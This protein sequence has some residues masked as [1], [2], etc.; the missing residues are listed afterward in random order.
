MTSTENCQSKLYSKEKFKK[1]N[2][3]ESN[4]NFSLSGRKIIINSKIPK[5]STDPKSMLC[6]EQFNKNCNGIKML[7]MMNI[8]GSSHSFLTN[9]NLSVLDSET[10]EE[11]KQRRN[12]A[13]QEIRRKQAEKDFDPVL[14]GPNKTIEQI[15]SEY[16]QK[17]QTISDE[18]RYDDFDDD[19]FVPLPL[20]SSL[21]NPNTL[22]G[23]KKEKSISDIDLIYWDQENCPIP[24]NFD[25][26]EVISFFSK[27]FPKLKFIKIFTTS[28]VNK[29]NNIIYNNVEIFLCNDKREA[30]DKVL[31]AEMTFDIAMN[32]NQKVALI[33][34]DLDFRYSVKKLNDK[35]DFFLL[36][37]ASCKDEDYFKLFRSHHNFNDF[38]RGEIPRDAKIVSG[39]KE[40]VA[41][42]VESLI[43]DRIKI[44][45]PSLKA[46]MHM[47]NK[48]DIFNTLTELDAFKKY[49][50]EAV[51]VQTNYQNFYDL[52]VDTWELN[53]SIRDLVLFYSFLYENQNVRFKGRY[54][55]CKAI[56]KFNTFKSFPKGK[57]LLMIKLSY[58]Q[59]WVVNYKGGVKV[60]QCMSKT[61]P[62]QDLLD[63]STKSLNYHERE[64]DIPKEDS[65]SVLQYY[66][67]A[68][69]KL[70]TLPKYTYVKTGYDHA[71]VFDVSI[72]IPVVSHD[73]TISTFYVKTS[74]TS[75]KQGEKDAAYL[76]L[77]ILVKNHQIEFPTFNFTN[78]VDQ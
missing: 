64:F 56:C 37:S 62:I 59:G 2:K 13:I 36:H 48:P 7:P 19:M 78:R 66:F 25:Y 32:P 72:D 12:N 77:Q 40:L 15:L 76:A 41:T 4:E 47:D 71:P 35:A 73:R 3:E 75:K 50:Q 24:K 22:L 52:D 31:I 14:I 54:L 30:A 42:A 10:E 60:S 51:L 70:K 26:S 16:E 58:K 27:A 46:A 29:K 67:Q 45:L 39:W 63:S 17:S 18:E 34:G 6:S 49:Y 44:T 20:P 74:A 53:F 57:I 23:F 65:K 38:I 28:E 11:K 69:A 33:S 1:L 55:M 43:D 8:I 68:I 9:E 61:I 21:L 5:I